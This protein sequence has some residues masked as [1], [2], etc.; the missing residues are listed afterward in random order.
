MKV[1]ITPECRAQIM[2][3][4]NNTDIEISG[5]GRIQ[6]DSLGNMVVTKVYLLDQENSAATTDLSEDAV[7]KCLFE[8][9]QDAGDLNFWWHSHVNMGV[10]W[11]GTDMATIEQFGSKGYLLATVFNKKG[12]HR[13]AY[14]QGDN[15]FIPKL[16]VDDI[17]TSFDQLPTTAQATA[18][19]EEIKTKAKKKEFK[20][21]AGLGR[22]TNQDYLWQDDY[23][24]YDKQDSKGFFLYGVGTHTQLMSVATRN[25]EADLIMLRDKIMLDKKNGWKFLIDREDKDALHDIHEIIYGLRGDDKDIEDLIN[26]CLDDLEKLEEYITIYKTQNLGRNNEASKNATGTNTTGARELKRSISRGNPTQ[27]RITKRGRPRK[28]IGKGI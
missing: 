15:G 19:L 23:D 5:L 26:H 18:W 28:E 14:Y 4:V 3:Y 1:Y 24:Y 9:R 10:F 17:S 22:Y 20:P 21:A 27:L 2:F 13:T 11:S 7:S 8:T 16:F 6:R 12:E 25:C